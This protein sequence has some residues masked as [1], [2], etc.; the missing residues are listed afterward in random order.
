MRNPNF[1]NRYDPRKSNLKARI[2]HA[3]WCICQ[4]EFKF[5]AAKNFKFIHH[6]LDYDGVDAKPDAEENNKFLNQN[7]VYF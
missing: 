5:D 6:P 1:Q 4:F 2:E 7:L 3:L